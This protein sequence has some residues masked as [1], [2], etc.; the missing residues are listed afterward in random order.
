MCFMTYIEPAEHHT[1]GNRTEV[2]LLRLTACLFS[3]HYRPFD[4]IEKSLA[5]AHNVFIMIHTLEMTEI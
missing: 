5:G 4:P 3:R 1:K 2:T